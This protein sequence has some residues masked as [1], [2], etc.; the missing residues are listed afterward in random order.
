MHFPHHEWPAGRDK[1]L[2]P[3]D[4]KVRAAGGQMG[5][6]NGWE[7]ANWFAQPGDDTSL[8]ATHT[9]N[10]SGPWETRI[11]EECEAVRDHCGVLDLPG[12]SRFKIKG[13]GADEWLRGLVTGGLPK[14][15]RVGLVYFSDHRGR[16]VTEMSV[17]R[18]AEDMF[19]LVTAATAQW[20]DRDWLVKHLPA[21]G[22]I[23]FE[24]WTDRMSTL[25]VTG[26]KSRDILSGLC[27]ADL[28]LHWLSSQ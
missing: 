20:H 7:R 24:D 9:W 13:T 8:E 3:V 23:V 11:R 14:I 22:D 27:D 12:F 10:R 17:T 28:T 16:I 15:G 25:I 5:A 21:D 1:K 4:A 6:Y 26:P 2:S 18:I 19:V